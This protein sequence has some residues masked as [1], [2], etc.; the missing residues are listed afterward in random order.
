MIKATKE[1]NSL[2]V[3]EKLNIEKII[4]LNYRFFIATLTKNNSQTRKLFKIVL[5]EDDLDDI[6]RESLFLKFAQQQK[7][8]KKYI[9]TIFD[10]GGTNYKWYL[11]EYL[12]GQIQNI[13]HSDFLFKPNF[14]NKKNTDQLVELFQDLHQASEKVPC[15][16]KKLLSQHNMREEMNWL[17]RAIKRGDLP[18]SPRRIKKF[19]RKR[20]KQFDAAP[21]VLT[22]CEPYAPHF[23]KVKNEIKL[24][25]WENVKF[26]NPLH[27]LSRI[28]CRIFDN[29]ELRKYLFN[30][31]QNNFP[32]ENFENIFMAEILMQSIHNLGYFAHTKN[33]DEKKY[34][35]KIIKFFR[36]N[37]IDIVK[38]NKLNQ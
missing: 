4:S 27:D 1:V 10:Y 2:I 20:K 37:I 15:K 31:M 5:F 25:D 21:P 17:E 3:K 28:W 26:S 32:I 13:N 11:R 30:K 36:Q 12:N 23:I 29:S 6:E 7:S 33:P 9:P 8:L 19:L 24:I 38:H 18:I 22:H 14:L 35:R 16:L 34:K